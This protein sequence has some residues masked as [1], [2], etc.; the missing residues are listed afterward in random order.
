[1]NLPTMIGSDEVF[2]FLSMVLRGLLTPSGEL[3]K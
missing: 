2:V 1:M 3:G